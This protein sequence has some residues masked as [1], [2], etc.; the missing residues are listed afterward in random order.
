MAA[1]LLFRVDASAAAKKPE[2]IAAEVTVPMS[3][4]P[5]VEEPRVRYLDKDGREVP[6]KELWRLDSEPT[7]E[8]TIVFPLSN[9]KFTYS[10]RRFWT[11]TLDAELTLKEVPASVRAKVRRE[12]IEAR[13][14]RRAGEH[15]EGE[16]RIWLR[17]SYYVL[18]RKWFVT[19]SRVL[20]GGRA[21]GSNLQ[22]AGGLEYET[23]VYNMKGEVISTGHT[24][25]VNGGKNFVVLEFRE[26]IFR[27]I[28]GGGTKLA[29]VK[30][31][32]SP[33]LS[34]DNSYLLI[35]E[36]DKGS[37]TRIEISTGVSKSWKFNPA[38]YPGSCG[39][40]FDRTGTK[41]LVRWG[42]DGVS[43]DPRMMEVPLESLQ[44]VD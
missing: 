3:A 5:A 16:E 20:S 26:N 2:K 37:L 15:S 23:F 24:S 14:E 44:A 33:A 38:S 10:P 40:S 4:E 39:R 42:C 17:E 43:P 41:L 32:E 11:V 36:A 7:A 6:R 13:K 8:R 22:W 12:L 29:E 9:K 35:S 1:I 34:S 21:E 25:V 28:D 18:D 19:G 30:A 27:L 31:S